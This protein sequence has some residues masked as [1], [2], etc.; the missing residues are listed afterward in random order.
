MENQAPATDSKSYQR[1]KHAVELASLGVAV[2]GMIAAARFGPQVD[3]LLRGIVGDNRWVR[4]ITTGFTYAIALQILSL[5]F[6]FYSSFVLEHRYGLSKQS[7][8]RWVWKEMKGYL[9]AAPLLLVLVLGLYAVLWFTGEWW[10][11]VAAVGWLLLTLLLAKILPVLILPLFYKVTRLE[12][13]ELLGRLQRLAEG[14]GLGIEGIYTLQLSDETRKANA[15]LAGLGKSRRVLLGDTLLTEFTPEE[16]EIVFAHEVGHH[17]H[18]HLLQ[19][20]AFQVV[21]TTAGLWLAGRVLALAA[22]PLGYPGPTDP[23]AFPLLLLVLGGF[24]L[25]LLPL[26]NGMAR[27]FERQ[28]DRYAL[29][30]TGNPTAYRSAFEKLGRMNKADAEP[31][32]LLVWLL[33]DHP[34]IRQRIAAADEAATPAAA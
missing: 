17:A 9:L 32:P 18:R 31:H 3:R 33:H 20:I 19:L 16:I 22:G 11:L 13:S 2:V 26:K 12:D 29:K 24:G 10:W 28:S 34:P 5:P 4:A 30:R 25:L 27:W 23:A 6:D 7:F 15:A 14:T 21:L 8:L 1:A